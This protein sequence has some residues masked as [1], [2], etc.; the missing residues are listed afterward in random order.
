MGVAPARAAIGVNTTPDRVQ[1]RVA[2][3]LLAAQAQYLL[4]RRVAFNHP[5]IGVVQH[6]AVGDGVHQRAVAGFFFLQRLLHCLQ[7]G[8]V[9]ADRQILHR[10]ALLIQHRKNTGFH[11]VQFAILA[12]VAHFTVPAV[13]RRNGAPQFL[14]KGLGMPVGLHQT[15]AVAQQLF[16]G[17]TADFAEFVVDMDNIAISIGHA[18][19]G[20]FIYRLTQWFQRQRLLDQRRQSLP[21]A[22]TC[23]ACQAMGGNLRPQRAGGHRPE[24]AALHR[25]RPVQ[26][27][28]IIRRIGQHQHGQTLARQGLAQHI[29]HIR[30]STTGQ[31]RPN[32]QH[33]RAVRLQAGQ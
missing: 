18:D 16:T 20:M 23:P 22:Q 12:P 1:R 14:V 3:N 5:A 17:I 6:N 11:P 13:A 28:R 7:V 31:N 33:I 27:R 30:S 10:Q 9:G 24:H 19:N 15:M 32:Q 21:G 2:E 26:H 25:H 29:Q 8:D 4:S